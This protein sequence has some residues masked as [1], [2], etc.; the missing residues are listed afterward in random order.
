MIVTGTGQGIGQAIAERFGSEG[1]RVI[2]ADINEAEV[3]SVAEG[4]V[5]S[6]WEPGRPKGQVSH[7]SIQIPCFKEFY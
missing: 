6:S 7:Q 4:I 3:S 5:A 1:S 2:L